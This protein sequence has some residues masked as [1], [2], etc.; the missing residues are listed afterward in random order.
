MVD[1]AEYRD[2]LI[3]MT[4]TNNLKNEISTAAQLIDLSVRRG[5][6]VTEYPSTD[7]ETSSL[8]EDL[9]VACADD[10]SPQEHHSGA[11][12]SG[13]ESAGYYD[14]WGSTDDGAEWRVHIVSREIG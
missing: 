11:G 8:L 1:V 5:Q 14:V 3:L 7:A 10:C 2:Y 13:P 4:T 9:G 6:T 12:H